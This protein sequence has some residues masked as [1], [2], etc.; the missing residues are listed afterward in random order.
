M[1]IHSM[2]KDFHVLR[3]AGA[4]QGAARVVVVVV[5]AADRVSRVSSCVN[6][7]ALT[8]SRGYVPVEFTRSDRESTRSDR[9]STLPDREST[10]PN[11]ESTRSDRES[12]R[13]DHESTLPDRESTR[14]NGESTRSDR[15]STR[16]DRESTLPDRESTRFV[17]P[18]Q[19]KFAA[20]EATP[21]ETLARLRRSKQ[22]DKGHKGQW[23]EGPSVFAD[24]SLRL[25]GRGWDGC[26][27]RGGSV[28]CYC[29]GKKE[30]VR[31]CTCWL[32]Y[33]WWLGGA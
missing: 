17:R 4:P 32:I 12:T 2:M 31:L 21:S 25:D 8:G 14:P 16:S 33:Y 19:A 1:T 3:A 26:R 11:G 24:C 7:P 28:S 30:G 23:V 15:E 5:A 29:V 20:L 18:P 9:E 27:H 6:P 10:R 13:S 22:G